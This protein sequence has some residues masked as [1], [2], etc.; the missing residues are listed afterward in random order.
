M[1]HRRPFGKSIPA[2]LAS[3][4]L[5]ASSPAAKADENPF[6]HLASALYEIRA[7]KEEL[8]HE[9]FVRHWEAAVRD[10]EVA[11]VDTEKALAEAKVEFRRFEGPRESKEYYKGYRD[12]PH[13]RHALVELNEAKKEIE[14]RK[15][16]AFDPA[17][18][19]I[20]AAIARVELAL[21]E[22]K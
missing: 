3:L 7:A 14:R 22:E 19:S 21:R 18:L 13:L 12:F 6:E 20:N 15:H 4:T 9:R 11:A 5:L 17:V 16:R 8:K 2:A 10:L 1:S